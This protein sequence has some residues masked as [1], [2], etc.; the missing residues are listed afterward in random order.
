MSVL[1][2]D[3]SKMIAALLK[4]FAL[5]KIMPQVGYAWMCV[6]DISTTVLK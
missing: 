2:K 4:S 5:I 1:N 3:S 6:G